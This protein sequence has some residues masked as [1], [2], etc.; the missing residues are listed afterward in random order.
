VIP[1]DDDSDPKHVRGVAERAAAQGVD[2]LFRFSNPP[3]ETST[4]LRAA[5]IVVVPPAEP[6]TDGRIVAEAQAM[7]RPVIASEIGVL[8][9]NL[10]APPR[11]TDKVSTGWLVRPDDSISL[12]HA[13][14][15]ALTLDDATL[16]SISLRARRF[17]EA[18]FSRQSVAAATLA[19]YT[20]VLGGG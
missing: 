7:A 19:V 4:L 12:A 8:P 13:I 9:E 17:A 6:A 18:T 5:D 16:H 3:A 14:G 2:G 1:R 20:S 11:A 15:A 10:L